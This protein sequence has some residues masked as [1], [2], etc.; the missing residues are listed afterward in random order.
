MLLR[1]KVHKGIVLDVSEHGFDTS[2]ATFGSAF[3]DEDSGTIYFF[4]TGASDTKFTRASIGLAISHDLINFRKLS[5]PI[6]SCEELNFVELVTPVV[7]RV[8]N[9][10]YMAF[11]CKP[12][13][14]FGKFGIQRRICLAF[15]DDPKGPWNFIKVIAKPEYLW[16]GK[17]IDLGPCSIKVSENEY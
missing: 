5:E 11:A 2:A 17:S 4:Y 12:L 15:S 8:G 13:S 14:K 6:L 1:H 9:Y 10:F 16:E 7:F 3:Y